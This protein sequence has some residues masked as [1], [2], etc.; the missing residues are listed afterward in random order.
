MWAQGRVLERCSLGGAVD[1]RPD[2]VRG[3]GR[4]RRHGDVRRRVVRGS[5]ISSAAGGHKRRSL[6]R[7]EGSAAR[8][9]TIARP[10]SGRSPGRREGDPVAVPHH[11]LVDE[12]AP[13][14]FTSSCDRSMRRSGVARGRCPRRRAPNRPTDSRYQAALLVHGADEIDDAGAAPQALRGETAGD[15]DG[16]E[17]CRA[18]RLDRK[19]GNH[20]IAELAAE[21]LRVGRSDDGVR[22][23][24]P[25]ASAA[26]YQ[27]SSSWNWCSQSTA[28]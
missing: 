24:L 18:D 17:I 15:D 25:H 9:S 26:G 19:I 7:W 11:R 10:K 1:H 2:I 22:C 8:Y 14:C 23:I 12:L 21:I 28:T 13:A 4:A 6:P 5:R 20:G 3:G 27:S 16:V